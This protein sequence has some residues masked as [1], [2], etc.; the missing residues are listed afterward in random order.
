MPDFV[1]MRFKRSFQPIGNIL[2]HLLRGN[3]W[4]GKIKQY[5]LFER[6]PAIVGPVVAAHARPKVWR[7]TVLVV[8]VDNHAWMSELRMQEESLLEKIRASQPDLEVR[9]IHWTLR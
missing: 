5:S 9:K 4:E 2:D 7:H 8:A 1:I 3:K 6:W